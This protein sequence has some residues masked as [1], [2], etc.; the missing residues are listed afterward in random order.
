ML[1][2]RADK[3]VL[4]QGRRGFYRR[5]VCALASHHKIITI[6][7]PATIIVVLGYD[8]LR[9]VSSVESTLQP[10][11]AAGAPL[12][13]TALPDDFSAYSTAA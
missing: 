7:R 8:R 10:P 2:V 6:S 11:T 3:K 4:F 9:H 5:D 12:P 13:E 1:A